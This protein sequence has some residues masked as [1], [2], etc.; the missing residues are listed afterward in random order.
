MAVAAAIAATHQEGSV[1]VRRGR[2]FVTPKRGLLGLPRG[3][4]DSLEKEYL[5]LFLLD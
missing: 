5:S 2:R 4:M 1:R 3:D